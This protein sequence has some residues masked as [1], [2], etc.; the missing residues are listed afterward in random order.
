MAGRERR[1]VANIDHCIS[2]QLAK[3]EASAFILEDLVGIWK[4]RHMG[5]KLNS[6]LSTW[7]F[8][9]FE[10]I[11]SYK[12]EELGKKVVFIDASYTS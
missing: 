8:Y 3:S 12:A 11:L 5:K 1:Y 9:R 6:K 7:A 2:K 4:Q 10:H